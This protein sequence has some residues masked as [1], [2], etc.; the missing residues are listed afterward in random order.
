MP[1]ILTVDQSKTRLALYFLFYPYQSE[2][3]RRKK[4]RMTFKKCKLIYNNTVH[5]IDLM[6]YL[7]ALTLNVFTHL[8]HIMLFKTKAQHDTMT[9]P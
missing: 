4:F 3:M 5:F 2:I 1:L 6:G 7:T 8:L 9:E